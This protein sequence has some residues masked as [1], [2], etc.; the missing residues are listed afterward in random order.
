VEGL[1]YLGLSNFIGVGNGLDNEIVGNVGDDSLV[2]DAGNDV[3]HAGAGS[4][5]LN[6]GVGRDTLNGGSGNDV[7]YVDD[8]RDIVIEDIND[9]W[10]VVFSTASSFGLS[11][12]VEELRYLGLTDFMGMGNELDNEI[13]GNV[14]DDILLGDTG[15]DVLHGG[16]GDDRLV[17]DVGCDT[18]I[19]GSGND[20]YYVDNIGD[21][22][23]ENTNDSWDVVFSTVASFSLSVNV[24]GL[25]YFGLSNFTG[26]GNELDNE[27]IGNVGDDILLADAGNDV[28][29]G[30][31]GN[32]TLNG[33]A[34]LDTLNGGGGDDV[35]YVDDARDII[36]EKH[37]NDSWDDVIST[38]ESFS[39]SV[40]LERLVY[41]GSSN[42]IGVGN[43]LGNVIVGNV[44]DDSLVGG[45]GD[46]LLNGGAGNDTLIGGIGSDSYRF[47]RN[48]G[49]DIIIEEDAFLSGERNILF[50]EGV[51]HNQLWFKRVENNLETS[52]IGTDSKVIFNDWYLEAPRS[53]EFMT[54]DDGGHFGFASVARLVDA[55]AAF[56]M[57]TS[58]TLSA[59]YQ[60][61]LGTVLGNN[62]WLELS[63]INNN[64]DRNPLNSN[65]NGS[66]PGITNSMGN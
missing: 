31:A 49:V 45:A 15:N 34:G 33:G 63:R 44:G 3:L 20:F 51:D 24:E 28:L 52:V 10:D 25:F 13:I 61:A 2:G 58:T 8:A 4:D 35:Y 38:V 59:D 65:N 14:G 26:L 43:D 39:L 22:V 56:E 5:T 27:I 19:G 55:M 64:N 46:D 54:E 40:N 11:S 17:G 1:T 48:S 66:T 57:P 42:F 50:F 60:A 6:G 62:W 30:D 29:H 36:I 16:A 37:I 12:N 47:A 41:L 18:L 9:A 21:I 23:I 32:D 53:L 7:Y